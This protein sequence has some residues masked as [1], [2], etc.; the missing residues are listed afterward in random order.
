MP[1]VLLSQLPI[2]AFNISTASTMRSPRYTG[3][4]TQTISRRDMTQSIYLAEG[5]NSSVHLFSQAFLTIR[6]TIYGL[7]PESGV[8][9]CS[10]RP[11]R[12]LER[13]LTSWRIS[14][15]QLSLPPKDHLEGWMESFGESSLQ[16]LGEHA[17]HYLA[18]TV[19]SS[20]VLVLKNNRNIE[21]T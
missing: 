15:A 12:Y 16:V 13:M 18:P 14:A 3:R 6:A 7:H 11:H 9:V 19:P 5:H 8:K 4:A 17:G 10:T 1:R 21:L 20:P 2:F